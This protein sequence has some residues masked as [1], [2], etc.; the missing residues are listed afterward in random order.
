MTTLSTTLKSRTTRLS[1]FS[2]HSA[3]EET[4][5]MAQCMQLGHIT[6]P[7]RLLVQ[8]PT[9]KGK[10]LRSSFKLLH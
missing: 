9:K 8:Q 10:G 4:D 1:V 7:G 3:K 2:F 6:D 5:G